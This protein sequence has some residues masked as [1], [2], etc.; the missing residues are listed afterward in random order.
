MRGKVGSK[1]KLTIRR[2]GEKPFEVTL[3]REE[4]KIQSVKNDIKSGDVAYIR[5]T[6]FSGDT[7]KWLRKP[8]NR[9]KRA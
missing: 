7:D 1:V 2:V 8:S 4:V 3:K 9:L 5:I 6:S